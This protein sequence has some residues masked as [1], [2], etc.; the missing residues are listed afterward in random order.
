[1]QNGFLCNKSEMRNVREQL[2]IRFEKGK[3]L[4]G[5]RSFHHFVPQSRSNISFKITSNDEKF[6][7][8]FNFFNDE[9]FELDMKMITIGRFVSCRYDTFWWIGMVEKIDEEAGDLV[10][11]FLH[12]HGPCKKNLAIK[13]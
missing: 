6:S 10:I 5:T 3:T 7:G 13:R 4:P 1:M 9:S 8:S 11:K 2:E 12:P